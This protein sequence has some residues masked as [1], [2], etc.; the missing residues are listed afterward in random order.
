MRYL[1]DIEKVEFYLD[2]PSKPSYLGLVL[3]SKEM[4]LMSDIIVFYLSGQ[5]ADFG[6]YTSQGEV[7]P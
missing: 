2:M 5:G 1:P 7:E 4:T 6:D 3:G